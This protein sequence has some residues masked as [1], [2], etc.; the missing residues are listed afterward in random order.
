M[1]D[2][3]N[4]ITAI[5]SLIGA[6]S[7]VASVIILIREVRETNRL[8]RAGN[9]Q[10][11]VDISGPFYL[12]LMQD[13]QLAELYARS[14][15]DFDNLDSID[16]QRYR[17]LLIWWLIFYENIF[18]Q[19]CLGL[20]DRHTFRPWWRDLALFLTEHNLSRH[21][22]GLRDL[23]QEEFASKVTEMLKKLELGQDITIY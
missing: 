8:A 13:R 1:A 11:L 15:K 3:L 23:F 10:S 2:W 5:S 7:L 18:Y 21:W 19:R 4:W 20:L 6:L 12:S 9:A 14:A 17:S 22:P 16:R